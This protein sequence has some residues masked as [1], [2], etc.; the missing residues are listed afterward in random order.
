MFNET[1]L[2][3]IVAL[4]HRSFKLLQW[5]R[6][7]LNAGTLN[8]STVENATAFLSRG[9]RLDCQ[10]SSPTFPRETRPDEADVEPFAHLFRRVLDHVV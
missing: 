9:P 2:S 5:V 7:Q 1:E 6:N 3:H 8:V 10:Q 4:H